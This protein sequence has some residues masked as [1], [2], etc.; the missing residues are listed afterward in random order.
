MGSWEADLMEQWLRQEQ[1]VEKEAEDEEHLLP[2]SPSSA[3]G[4]LLT[5]LVLPCRQKIQSH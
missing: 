3:L 5:C 4:R 2:P 1:E